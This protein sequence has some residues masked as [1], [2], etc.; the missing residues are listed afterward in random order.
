M[1]MTAQE[2]QTLPHDQLVNNFQRAVELDAKSGGNGQS[3]F[4]TEKLKEELMRRLNSKR[5]VSVERREVGDGHD[6]FS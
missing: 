5:S 3:P 2:L 4:D 1:C 6:E